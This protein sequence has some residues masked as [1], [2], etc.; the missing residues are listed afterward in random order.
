MAGSRNMWGIIWRRLSG[1]AIDYVDPR[2]I[3]LANRD[4]ANDGDDDIAWTMELTFGGPYGS[5]KDDGCPDV[6]ERGHWGYY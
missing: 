4:P 1:S 6:R 5:N 3:E 2:T